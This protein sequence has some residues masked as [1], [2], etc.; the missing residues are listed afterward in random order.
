MTSD[1][2]LPLL[3]TNIPISFYHSLPSTNTTAKNLIAS[4]EKGTRIVIANQQTAGRGQYGRSFHSPESHGIYM[5]FILDNTHSRWQPT[6]FTIYAAVCVAKAIEDVA[7]KTPTIKWVNDIFL[8]GKKVCG[9]LTETIDSA[10]HT[11]VVGIGMNVTSPA[12]G[13]PP[14]I[15]DIAGAIFPHGHPQA[16]TCHLAAAVINPMVHF[17]SQ[18]LQHVIDSYQKRLKNPLDIRPALETVMEQVY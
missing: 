6:A 4:G 13:F 17:Q 5:S 3:H 14:D 18:S 8:D 2:L 1:T 10:P 15:A 7:N 11:V 12:T 16:A 9:I